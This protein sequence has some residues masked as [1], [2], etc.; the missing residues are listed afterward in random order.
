MA[1]E[2]HVGPHH[3]T[4]GCGALAGMSPTL[5]VTS[6][7]AATHECV[8]STYMCSHTTCVQTP[9]GIHVYPQDIACP[10]EPTEHMHTLR[11]HMY[12]P[13]GHT[14]AIC[15][16]G[17]VYISTRYVCICQGHMYTPNMTCMCTH[18]THIYAYMTT[19]SGPKAPPSPAPEPTSPIELAGLVSQV[20]SH[21]TPSSQV[22]S[23]EGDHGAP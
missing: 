7:A 21:E 6:T 13:R 11:T 16:M 9:Q 18:R 2:P 4:W 10:T 17:H 23:S 1:G 15:N 14:Y 12:K 19:H 20:H 8:Q 5:L 22:V 3:R